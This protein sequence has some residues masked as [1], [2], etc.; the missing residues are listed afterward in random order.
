M[1][2]MSPP[3]SGLVC[4]RR[5]IS[6]AP[7]RRG[8]ARSTT[9]T[10]GRTCR[11]ILSAISA[12]TATVTSAPM[13][14]ITDWKI[15]RASE[16]SSTTRTW[17]PL[18]RRLSPTV[19]THGVMMTTIPRLGKPENFSP[20]FPPCVQWRPG[21][22]GQAQPIPAHR[23]RRPRPRATRLRP[24]ALSRDGRLFELRHLVLDHLDPDRRGAAL[25]LRPEAGR[26]G[27]QLGRLAGG[28]PL[29]ALR[30][31][32]DGGARLGVSD[33][34]WALLLGLSARRTDVG[35]DHGVAQHGRAGHDHRGH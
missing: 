16:L 19:I 23:R 28:E 33:G 4:R 12:D 2:G 22:D 8:M 5:S 34:R 6:H 9:I 11:V 7:S 18:R 27:H 17:M 30:G 3:R 24:A 29:H 14:V 26:A 10:S 35:V 31:G 25:R 20:D 13:Y 1:A 32:L 21:E 15:S